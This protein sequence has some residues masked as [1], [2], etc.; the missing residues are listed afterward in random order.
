[1]FTYIIIY[2]RVSQGK[3]TIRN[4]KVKP[5]NIYKV[6]CAWHTNQ[7]PARYPIITN[8][9]DFFSCIVEQFKYIPRKYTFAIF[10]A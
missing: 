10:V 7:L 6:C 4:K 3:A 9:A 1:M 2:N 8:Y 5:R